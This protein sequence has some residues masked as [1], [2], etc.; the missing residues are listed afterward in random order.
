MQN[1]KSIFQTV[2]GFPVI[3][4]SPLCKTKKILSKLYKIILHTFL[5]IIIIKI[6]EYHYRKQ[7]FKIILTEKLQNE[8]KENFRV[9]WIKLWGFPDGSDS[10]ESACNV[11][12]PRLESWIWKIPGEGNATYSSILAWRIPWTDATVHGVTKSQTRLSN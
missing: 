10:K 4:L 11:G 5:K 2:L 6:V 8:S 12:V 9:I 7:S 1:Q 3:F